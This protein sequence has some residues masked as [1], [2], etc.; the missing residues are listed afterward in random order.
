[1]GRLFL[2]CDSIAEL[3]RAKDTPGQFVSWSNSE[4]AEWATDLAQRVRLPVREDISVWIL[5][6]GLPKTTHLLPLAWT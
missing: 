4:Q 5:D 1:M 2:N 6:T 3:R